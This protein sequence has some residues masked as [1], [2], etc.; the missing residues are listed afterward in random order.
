M[1]E[2]IKKKNNHVMTCGAPVNK[3]ASKCYKI[4]RAPVRDAPLNNKEQ[5][6]EPVRKNIDDLWCASK[7]ERQ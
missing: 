2:K 4:F 7:Q 5:S 1:K 6:C 3:S